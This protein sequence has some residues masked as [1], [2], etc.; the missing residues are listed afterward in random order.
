MKFTDL[1][2]GS[3]GSERRGCG[4]DTDAPHTCGH[5]SSFLGSRNSLAVLA[6]CGRVSPHAF[7]LSSSTA[8]GCY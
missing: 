6:A 3:R 1:S 8:H 2:R 5:G 4:V 7:T